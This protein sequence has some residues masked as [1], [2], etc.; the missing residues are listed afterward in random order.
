MFSET[1]KR[2]RLIAGTRAA[3]HAAFESEYDLAPLPGPVRFRIVRR[4]LTFPRIWRLLGI[5]WLANRCLSFYEFYLSGIF[6]ARDIEVHLEAVK[7]EQG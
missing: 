5:A 3:A 2:S 6:R 1:P 7:E 4:R